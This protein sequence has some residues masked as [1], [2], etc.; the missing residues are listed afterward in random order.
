M[1]RTH[2]LMLALVLASGSSAA[3]AASP[4]MPLQ[5]VL[6]DADGARIDQAVTVT[7][8]LYDG[9]E[10]IE[11]LWTETQSVDVADGLFVVYLGTII[12]L[13][14]SLFSDQGAHWLGIAVQSDP[15]MPRVRL[16]TTPYAAHADTCSASPMPA[17]AGTQCGVGQ[18]VTG[19]DAMGLPVCQAPVGAVYDGTDFALSGK[20]C[21]PGQAMSGVDAAGFPICAEMIG[22]AGAVYAGQG[23]PSGQAVT[24]FSALGTVECTPMGS[25]GG[26]T[27]QGSGTNK[28]IA[29]FTGSSTLDDSIIT[30]SSNKIGVNTAFPGRTLEVKGDLEVTG[31]FYWGG[32]KFSTSSCVVIG[33]SSCSSACSKHGMSCYKAMAI[34]KESTSTSCSQSGFKFC[35]CRN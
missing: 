13:K 1:Q 33:G 19:F 3:G 15:E 2:A 4:L 14:S 24:G 26:D 28:K 18:M 35:C 6:T 29:M 22:A 30:Q 23:C 16:G 9:A 34:D 32:D 10:E 12:P 31:D 7:F 8:A 21:G 20:A 17:F 25:G 11:P 5:G 27:L